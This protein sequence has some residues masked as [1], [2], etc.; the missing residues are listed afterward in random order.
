[1]SQTTTTS[2]TT[3]TARYFVVSAPGHYGDRSRVWSSHRTLKAAKKAASGGGTTRRCPSW[4]TRWRRRGRG[5]WRRGCGPAMLPDSR[6]GPMLRR[7]RGSMR[8]STGR[9]Q[10]SGTRPSIRRCSTRHAWRPRCSSGCAAA[11]A[12][13]ARGR[14]I[15]TTPAPTPTSPWPK[16]SRRAH[17]QLDQSAPCCPAR[18]PYGHLG[19]LRV[20]PCPPVQAGHLRR[21][22]RLPP[23][24]RHVQGRQAA[25]HRPSGRADSSRPLIPPRIVP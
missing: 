8:D 19:S 4:P 11:S 22:E 17:R 23:A 2:T 9:R 25:A 5:G 18:A 24:L 12:A 16:P 7:S 21:D 20:R 3:A 1:M 13:L 10:T 6:H 14:S 15:P